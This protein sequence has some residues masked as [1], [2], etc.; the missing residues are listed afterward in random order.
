MEI[1]T[2]LPEMLPLLS[3]PRCRT[4]GHF[5]ETPFGGDQVTCPF[6]G[7]SSDLIDEDTDVDCAEDTLR[8]CAGCRVVFDYGCTHASN[9]CT[10]DVCHAVL[11]DSYELDG[12]R[13]AGMPRFCEPPTLSQLLSLKLRL[14]SSCD[15]QV[16]SRASYQGSE[17]YHHVAACQSA[18]ATDSS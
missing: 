9:G 4:R 10:D 8:Y 1:E 17:N 15:R 12:R 18:G 3:C 6:C 11:V 2:V 7:Q 14:R 16:C 13:Q 5:V